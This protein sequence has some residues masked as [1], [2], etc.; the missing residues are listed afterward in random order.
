M[1]YT[2]AA[3]LL[4]SLVVQTNRPDIAPSGAPGPYVVYWPGASPAERKNPTEIG[5]LYT[6][7]LL[8]TLVRKARGAV[9]SRV[10]DAIRQQ[11][12][13]VVLWAIPPIAGTPPFE[14]PFSAVIV[15]RG[16]Y[17][18]VPR[19]EPLWVE[20][21]AE[22]LRQLDPERS[23]REVGVMAAFPRS[24]F[25]PGRSVIIYRVLPPTEPGGGSGVQRFGRIEWNGTKP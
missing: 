9:P 24:A 23:F 19:V 6:P 14:R 21:H 17:S 8:G 25:V 12:P 3:V 7:E 15:E 20:Q 11:T 5:L 13:I 16:D 18:A 2:V 1:K 22:D 4:G 10:N